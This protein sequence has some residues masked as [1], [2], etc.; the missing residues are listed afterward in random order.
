MSQQQNLDGRQVLTEFPPSGNKEI[1]FPAALELN[2]LVT[3]EEKPFSE[4]N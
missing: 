3:S 2:P 1:I 4:A